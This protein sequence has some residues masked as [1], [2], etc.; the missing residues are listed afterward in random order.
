MAARSVE[1]ASARKAHHE[2]TTAATLRE[3]RGRGIGLGF[4][5][6]VALC[7]ACGGRI[8]DPGTPVVPGAGAGGEAG[9]ADSTGGTAGS[10]TGGSE[11]GY[12]DPPCPDVAPPEG[13]RE[14]DPL[15]DGT[16]CPAGLAC[17]PYVEHPFGEGCDAQTFGT[18]CRRAGTGQHGDPCGSG[19]SGCGP[20]HLC[21]IGALAG[22][23][24]AKICTF[25]GVAGCPPGMLC[26]ETDVKGYG[27]CT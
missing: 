1:R 19:T 26:G 15:G 21:V 7:G 16:D 8:D 3:M 22:R 5:G 2:A 24:C 4:L 23:R 12:T 9:A 25:D 13:T 6:L 11:P 20:G 17:Y 18:A 14:C 27:V 10:G